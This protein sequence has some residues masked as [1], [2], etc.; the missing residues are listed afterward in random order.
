LQVSLKERFVFDLAYVSSGEMT[1]YTFLKS[2]PTPWL[3]DEVVVWVKSF[4]ELY[5]FFDFLAARKL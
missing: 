3:L 1:P 2:V 5:S 4:R